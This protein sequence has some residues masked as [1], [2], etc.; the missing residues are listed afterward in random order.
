M[1][2]SE[3]IDNNIPRLQL[4]DTVIKARQLITDFKLTHLPVVTENKFLGLISEEDLLDIEEI[5]TTIEHI[6]DCFIVSFIQ[7]DS[8]GGRYINTGFNN[9]GA[10]K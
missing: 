5:K 2:T 6:Q 10:Q 9:G 8:V 4:L 7:D 1:L 3:L